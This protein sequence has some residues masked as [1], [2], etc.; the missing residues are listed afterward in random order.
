MNLVL[1]NAFILEK[2]AVFDVKIENG[3]IV[4]IAK[5]IDEQGFDLNGKI[6]S[7]GLIDMHT[8]LREP[9]FE[10]KETIETG[11]SAGIKGGYCALCPMPNTN[12]TCDNLATLNFIKGKTKNYNLFP[13]CAVT[14]GLTTN[15]LTDIELLKANGAIAFSND[16]KPVADMDVLK[17]AL[18]F[19]H[20][21]ISHA[22]IM[23]LNGTPESEYKAV[24]QEIE[25][26]RKS[27]GKYHFAHISTKESIE[28][29]RQA[30]REGLNLTCETAPH[31]FV[32]SKNEI[33]RSNPIFKVNPPLREES[34]RL[35]VIAALK[36]GTI[37]VIATDHAPHSL[38]EKNQPYLDAPMGLVGLETAL[39]LALTYLKDYLSFEEI[40][41]KFTTNPAKIMGIDNLGVIKEGNI[42]NLTI[43]DP[44][45]EWEVK[46]NEFQSKCKFTPFEGMC[47]KGKAVA[48]IV[49]GELYEN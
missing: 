22:E 10:Y 15:E 29:I 4:K 43:I 13:I 8:H 41:V 5:S 3:I 37:D 12:P 45:L 46:G 35:A 44:S 26:L 33:N 34:D 31:Y 47:L 28:L 40:L 19:N 39:G 20:L 1:K 21:I 7:R 49:N 11:I 14:K 16:G 32:L 24:E 27:G 36:D 18:S 25:T 42:A 17:K 30:K 2:N 23:E 9:G 38:E 48:T 6:L